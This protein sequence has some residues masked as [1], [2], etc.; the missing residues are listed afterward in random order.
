MKKIIIFLLSLIVFVA[1]KA[2]TIKVTYVEKMDLTEKL[3][4]FDNP[5]IKQMIIEKTGKPKYFELISSNG[6]SIYEKTDRKSKEIDN[7]VRVIGGTGGD[8]MLYKN[9][10][11]GIYILQTEFMS[12]TFL[13]EDTLPRYDWKITNETKKVGD[14][15]CKKA[16]LEDGNNK[17][18]AW[19]TPEIPSN[20][21]PRKYYGLPGLILKLKTGTLTIEAVNISLSR[22]NISIPKPKKGKKLTQ[23]EFDKIKEEKIKNLTGGKQNSNGIKIIKM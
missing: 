7:G 1:C 4:S 9:H 5:M 23:K 8:Y 12:R 6:I 15:L 17:I 2:Q 13:I 11:D 22:E 3:K 10:K 20:E 21:G 14:Y 19:F 18:V 16:V